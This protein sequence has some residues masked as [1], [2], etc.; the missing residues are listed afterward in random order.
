VTD[1]VH[2]TMRQLC[3]RATRKI[4]LD[5][6]GID[7]VVPD[8]TKPFSGDGGIVEVNASPGI[9]MHHFPNE[10]QPRDVGA[11][12][13]EMLYP[14]GTPSRIPVFSITGTN[15]K[16]T[17][18]RMI[19]HILAGTG[20]T[21]GMTTTDGIWIGDDEIAR[22]D[23]TGPWSAGVILSDPTVD[24]AVLETARGGIVRSGLGYD[25]SDISVMTNI[26]ADHLGQDGIET[27]DDI[28]RI[29]KLVA[30][31]VREGGTLILNADD[32]HLVRLPEQERVAAVP[33][34]IVYFSLD[35][36]N[37]VV[38]SHISAGGTAYVAAGGWIEEFSAGSTTR[39]ARIA[40]IPATLDGTAEFQIYNVLAS[41]AA[42]RAYG[43]NPTQIADA[44]LEFRMERQGAGRVNIYALR[45]GYVVVD[46]GHNP[47][48]LRAMCRMI[49]QW[50]AS[51]TTAVLA[52]PGDRNNA[53]IE[54]SARA[55]MCGFDRVIVREDRDLRGR[56]PGEVAE[57]L[58]RVIRE[59]R[60]E[61]PVEIILDELDAVAAAVS[62][63]QPEEVIIAFCDR[64]EE[65]TEWLLQQ[66]A[67]PVT[68]FQ[69][70]T[71][72][73]EAM[74]SAA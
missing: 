58:S 13:V 21:I 53:L 14:A 30:E 28:V 29:K 57:I 35:G 12:I 63:M 66:G 54:E 34:Q 7:L 6:C 46:Y 3:E 22:G 51:Y 47:A 23:M 17:V 44:L 25:W 4:G 69:R 70:L 11:A 72:Y 45:G 39:I 65:V 19:R 50:H 36:S 62:S 31:R 42:C 16:T 73:T 38:D 27:I 49:S 1:H 61:R 55:A 9:R 71:A 52:V 64:V 40:S 32:E 15:G 74:I 68:E 43:M 20:Q 33:K 41:T 24:V 56:Q 37:P 26:Q 60:P 67:Q 5:V 8:I 10:G 48:A 59:E 18:T 2:P